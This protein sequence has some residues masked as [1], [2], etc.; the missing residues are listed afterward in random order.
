MSY[1]KRFHLF[2]ID[3]DQSTDIKELNFRKMTHINTVEYEM[4]K[5]PQSHFFSIFFIEKIISFL[6]SV[7]LLS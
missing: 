6:I 5:Y 4:A 2:I 7:T 1:R 3:I